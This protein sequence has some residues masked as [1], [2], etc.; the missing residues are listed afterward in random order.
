M[1]IYSSPDINFRQLAPEQTRKLK[2]T[3]PDEPYGDYFLVHVAW[4]V[5]IHGDIA[6]KFKRSTQTFRRWC[7]LTLRISRSQATKLNGKKNSWWN[8]TQCMVTF[9]RHVASKSSNFT[10][11]SPA[12]SWV[13]FEQIS[14]L[15]KIHELNE[16]AQSTDALFNK[17]SQ[18]LT[19]NFLCLSSTELI[20]FLLQTSRRMFWRMQ[21]GFFLRQDTFATWH[22]MWY[23]NVD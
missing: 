1:R 9:W 8:K 12:L 2:R 6:T 3:F 4:N 22:V 15:V 14:Q 21:K 23:G 5:L 11:V 17:F 13:L 18:C 10:R 7:D 16:R 20:C 19:Q